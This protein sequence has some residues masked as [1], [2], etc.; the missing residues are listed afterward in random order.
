MKNEILSRFLESVG[1]RS[2]Q[3]LM[4]KITNE[5]NFLEL[6]F[7]KLMAHAENENGGQKN[8]HEPKEQI[9]L[10]YLINAHVK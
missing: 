3:K 5:I 1:T 9:S 8:T 7:F 6:F 10:F 4:K 2:Y